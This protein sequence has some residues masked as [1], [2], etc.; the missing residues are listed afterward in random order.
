MVPPF[1]P[2]KA[3]AHNELLGHSSQPFLR[4]PD[5]SWHPGSRER[6]RRLVMSFQEY[7]R[8]GLLPAIVLTLVLFYLLAFR[9][10]S[11]HSAELD[12]PLNKARAKLAHFTEQ[13]TN[14]STFDFQ[15]I[16]NQLNET[17]QDLVLLESAK[18]QLTSRLELPQSIKE[19]FTSEFRGADYE[20]DRD[21]RR[22]ALDRNAKALQVRL[23]NKVV[24][25]EYNS[26]VAEP[27]LL[28][29][30]LDFADHLLDS[31]IRC[32]VTTIHLLEVSALAPTNYP[33]FDSGGH[34]SQIPLELEFTS[35]ADNALKLLQSLPLKSDEIRAAGLFEPRPGKTPL[36][37][38][39]LLIRKQSPERL[40]EVRVWLQVAGFVWH[41]SRE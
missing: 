41:D 3:Q 17:R 28:W 7:R 9:S 2:K 33:G 22:R 36:L 20:Q 26:A 29:P 38:D 6:R 1:L 8:R 39:H 15:H 31:A 25:P 13:P 35:P 4:C 21:R 30:A 34:W 16:T 40:D 18:K 12:Q 19:R 11:Q 14:A 10:L 5:R 27:R 23:E 37:I 32:K 24:L